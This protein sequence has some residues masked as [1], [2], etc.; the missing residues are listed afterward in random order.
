MP[1]VALQLAFGNILV[2]TRVDICTFVCDVVFM[3]DMRTRRPTNLTLD[4]EILAELD[5]WIEKQPHRLK[6][7]GVIETAIREFLDRQRKV[8]R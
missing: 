5:E 1:N 8:K 6:R 2:R 7:S 4:P 3:Q